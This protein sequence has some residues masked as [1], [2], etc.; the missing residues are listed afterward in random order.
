[1]SWNYNGKTPFMTTQA[2]NEVMQSEEPQDDKHQP[3][4]GM[5]GAGN[6][7]MLSAAMAIATKANENSDR[8]VVLDSLPVQV[9]ML[10]ELGNYNQSETPF[11]PNN[12]R[13]RRLQQRRKKR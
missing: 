8:I 11:V 4:I 12:R 2:K 9:R 5:I 6:S 10:E 13:N 1:M 7:S 3:I